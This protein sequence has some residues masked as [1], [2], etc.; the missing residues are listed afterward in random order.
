M[1]DRHGE[2][3]SINEIHEKN[4]RPKFNFKAI[5]KLLTPMLEVILPKDL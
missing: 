1:I 4:D 3:A 5:A 2:I